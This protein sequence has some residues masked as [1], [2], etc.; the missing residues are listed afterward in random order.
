MADPITKAAGALDHLTTSELLAVASP[1]RRFAARHGFDLGTA[2][3]C[4]RTAS[5]SRTSTPE[6]GAPPRKTCPNVSREPLPRERD[7]TGA[8]DH[9]PKPIE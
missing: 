4:P 7:R 3:D 1:R 6:R 2:Y 8:P 9:D 5:A